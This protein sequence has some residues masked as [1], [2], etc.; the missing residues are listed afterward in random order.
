MGRIA[1]IPQILQNDAN[2]RNRRSC[3][4]YVQM[5]LGHQSPMLKT[6]QIICTIDQCVNALPSLIEQ[7][8]APDCIEIT[9]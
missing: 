5:N 3:V 8:A 2:D 1:D 7:P 6:V 9:L 4:R